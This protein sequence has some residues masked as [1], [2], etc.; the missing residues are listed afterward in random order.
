MIRAPSPK[1][2]RFN[3]TL[4]GE[5]SLGEEVLPG[6]FHLFQHPVIILFTF[7]ASHDFMSLAC[8]QKA[9]LIFWSTKVQYSIS[10]PG[11]QVVANRMIR[12]IPLELVG[13]VFPTTLIILEGQGIDVILGMNWIKMC[14]VVSDIYAHLVHLDSPVFVKITLLLSPIARLQASVHIVVAKSLNEIPVVYEYLDVFPDD[15]PGM[16]PN[17]SIEFKIELQPCNTP[18]YKRMYPMAL[19]ELVEMKI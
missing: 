12:K 7:G 9:K 2:G 5:I 13:R 18:T 1:V 3:F 4:V 14:K 11:G 16:P 8:A 19:D 15:L 6:T 10:T 17:R